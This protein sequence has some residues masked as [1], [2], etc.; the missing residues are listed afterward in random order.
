MCTL[1]FCQFGSWV[2]FSEC[3]IIQN[4]LHSFDNVKES[5]DNVCARLVHLVRSLV[6]NHEV[7]G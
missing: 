5:D 6:A 7:P 4:F 3:K 1:L 2:H